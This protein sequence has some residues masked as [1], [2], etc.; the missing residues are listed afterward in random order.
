LTPNAN[1]SVSTTASLTATAVVTTGADSTTLTARNT[2]VAS[3]TAVATVIEGMKGASSVGSFAF[4][5]KGNLEVLTRKLYL[6]QLPTGT[7]NN[8]ED[9]SGITPTDGM[10]YNVLGTSANREPVIAVYSSL[11]GSWYYQLGRNT[12]TITY[13]NPMI[14]TYVTM[15]DYINMNGVP[16]TPTYWD[17]SHDTGAFQYSIEPIPTVPSVP[18]SEGGGTGNNT[19][20]RW[21]VE[22][23]TDPGTGQY[24]LNSWPAHNGVGPTWYSKEFYRPQVKGTVKFNIKKNK[25][26]KQRSVTFNYNQVDHMYMTCSAISQPFTVVLVGII[27]SYPTAKYGHYLLDSGAEPAIYDA[28][29]TGTD[30]FPDEGTNP[31]N[32]LLFQKSRAR[33]AVNQQP[34]ADLKLCDKN[35]KS[36]HTE[37][38]RPR[39][40]YGVFNGSSSRIGTMDTK[41]KYDQTGTLSNYGGSTNFSIGRRVNRISDNR[42]SH[43]SLWDI[44]FFHRALSKDELT[45][46]YQE[47]AS[48]Y[49]FKEYS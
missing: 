22:D 37:K 2:A 33:I 15:P 19:V 20:W 21:K 6:S 42:A 44:T 46:Y 10:V 29:K 26:R 16:H 9:L 4:K 18:N 5:F 30:F 39:F 41:Y 8:I 13:I 34:N 36:K 35:I 45:N 27:H 25:T 40:F 23:L 49:H 3:L 48:T 38:P 32:V 31:R 24:A 7:V 47:M 1:Y 28:N 12:T 17:K 14:G 43:M 11:S